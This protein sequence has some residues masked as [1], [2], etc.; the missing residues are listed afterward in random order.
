MLAVGSLKPLSVIRT[1]HFARPLPLQTMDA[2]S[3]SDAKGI[4]KLQRFFAL[5]VRGDGL[6]WAL[7]AASSCFTGFNSA[8][9]AFNQV[10]KRRPW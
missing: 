2:I 8:S 4:R 3:L 1:G 7:Q 9:I 10:G 5:S 6:I